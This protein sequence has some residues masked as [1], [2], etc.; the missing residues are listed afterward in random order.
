MGSELFQ[1]IIS[2]KQDNKGRD[3]WIAITVEET[4]QWNALCDLI[5]DSRLNDDPRFKDNE[6]RKNNEDILDEIISEFTITWAE[7]SKT[8]ELPTPLKVHIISDHLSEY[9][10]KE[11]QILLKRNNENVED[12]HSKYRQFLE[13]H[14]YNVVDVMSPMHHKK[15]HKALVHWNSVNI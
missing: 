5:G 15:Q 14:Q 9:F 3:S 8:F 2:C 10:E 1:Q 12:V 6:S 11:G 4:L 13:R 7:C